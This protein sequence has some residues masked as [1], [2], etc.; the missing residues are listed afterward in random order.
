[1]SDLDTDP[2]K[3]SLPWAT[4]P[5]SLP[6]PAKAA[7]HRHFD[8]LQNVEMFLGRLVVDYLVAPSRLLPKLRRTP[9]ATSALLLSPADPLPIASPAQPN[10]HP[11]SFPILKLPTASFFS[12]SDDNPRSLDHTP[13]P[14]HPA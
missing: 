9:P 2:E 14:V 12:S 1:M 8:I 6:P 3:D 11:M 4:Y 7:P 13:P 5:T 10:I